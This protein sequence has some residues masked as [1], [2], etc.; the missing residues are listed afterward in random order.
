MI[1]R[2]VRH[3]R[4]FR[5]VPLTAAVSAAVALAAGV[6]TAQAPSRQTASSPFTT[7]TPASPSGLPLSIDY[8]N[9]NDPNAKP[10]AVQTVVQRL[11]PGTRID[12]TVPE[13]C[14]ASDAQFAS[15][16]AAACPPGSR[17][18][19]G[20]IDLDTG[21]VAGPIPRIV[22]GRVTLFN[23]EGEL[24]L[25][26]ET[27]NTPGAPI[28]FASR[29]KI[30]GGTIT[31]QVPPIPAAP[32]PEP[33]LAIKRVRVSVEVVTRGSGGSQRAYLLTPPEC[34]ASGQWLNTITF[35]YRDG[36]SQTVPTSSP[37]ARPGGNGTGATP[38]LRLA[39]EPNSARVGRA[40]RFRFQVT[41]AVR[42]RSRSVAGATI[43]FAGRRLATDRGGRATIVHRFARPGRYPVSA[44]RAGFRAATATV[45]VRQGARS[46]TF[47]G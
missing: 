11:H 19:G 36:V 18:G 35:T 1:R 3:S 6:A 13:R 41:A 40:T 20:E 21:L 44:S 29:S 30:E 7:T 42:G 14:A 38:A 39:V 47:T 27:T 26:T 5:P 46:P 45:T 32:P 4:G 2:P 28:R 37:C 24:I 23:N 22:N 25:F 31:S 9:P 15:Q 10:Y 33:F 34:P 16:G 8:V 43:R 12:T 17:V